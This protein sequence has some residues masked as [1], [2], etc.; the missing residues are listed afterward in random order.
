[1]L[2][3][4]INYNLEVHKT[5]YKMHSLHALKLQEVAPRHSHIG[6]LYQEHHYDRHS[7]KYMHICLLRAKAQPYP[8][9]LMVTNYFSTLGCIQYQ[10][11]SITLRVYFHHWTWD[12][13]L[14]KCDLSFHHWKL[15]FLLPLISSPLM[16]PTPYP[17]SILLSK[18]PQ[19]LI[20]TTYN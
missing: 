8:S 3:D 2:K 14:F 17:L 1:M 13:M 10:V 6:K 20:Y 12:L 4:K 19:D 11:L 15:W 9:K 18:D 16:F 5:W 7:S